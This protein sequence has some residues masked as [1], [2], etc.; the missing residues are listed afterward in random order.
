MALMWV[1]LLNSMPYK[2]FVAVKKWI[3]LVRD[4]TQKYRFIGVTICE[5]S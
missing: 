1:N 3:L 2:F 4:G 5:S